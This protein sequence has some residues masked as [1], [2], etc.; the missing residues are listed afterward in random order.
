MAVL[1]HH[2]F[3]GVDDDDDVLTDSGGVKLLGQQLPQAF[4][5]NENKF[6]RNEIHLKLS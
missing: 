5:G 2:H 4:P 6:P 1:T 3:C